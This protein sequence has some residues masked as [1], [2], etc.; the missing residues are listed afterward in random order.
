MIAKLKLK[1]GNK[2]A[3][4]EKV[5]TCSKGKNLRGHQSRSSLQHSKKLDLNTRDKKRYNIQRLEV[6]SAREK[7]MHN[8][9][10]AT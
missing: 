4:G 2:L 9:C 10:Q 8:R 3:N 6:G 5:Q 1:R 7:Q